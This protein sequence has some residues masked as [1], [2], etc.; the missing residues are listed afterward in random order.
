MLLLLLVINTSFGIFMR[1]SAQI[2]VT[3]K[4]GIR[5][6]QGKALEDVLKKND[7][8]SNP[9]INTGKYFS[10]EFSAE[11]ETEAGQKLNSI[12]KSVLTNP[13]LETFQILELKSK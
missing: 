2:I 8:E 13:V 3:L 4:D 11:N 6:T 7:F 5:D 1:F 12:C 9:H 10:F